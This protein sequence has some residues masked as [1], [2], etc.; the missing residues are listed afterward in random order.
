M[1]QT[2]ESIFLEALKRGPVL[3]LDNMH[4][5]THAATA[6]PIVGFSPLIKL[7]LLAVD[8]GADPDML[9]FNDPARRAGMSEAQAADIT[10]VMYNVGADDPEL[11]RALRSGKPALGFHYCPLNAMYFVDEFGAFGKRLKAGRCKGDNPNVTSP[12]VWFDP[13]PAKFDLDNPRHLRTLQLVKEHFTRQG[14]HTAAERLEKCMAK[15]EVTGQG[16]APID[17]G[18]GVDA[19]LGENGTLTVTSTTGGKGA[20]PLD[21]AYLGPAVAKYEQAFTVRG[22]ADL[23]K[24]ASPISGAVDLAAAKARADAE[25]AREDAAYTP[26]TDRAAKTIRGELREALNRCSAENSSN[27]PDFILAE[28]LVGTLAAFNHA[29]NERDRWHGTNKLSASIHGAA[30]SS[31]GAT[32]GEDPARAPTEEPVDAQHLQDCLK[33]SRHAHIPFD[34]VQAMPRDKLAMFLDALDKSLT[35]EAL[36]AGRMLVLGKDGGKSSKRHYEVTGK[37]WTE[38][39][40]M[41]RERKLDELLPL[42]ERTLPK[43]VAAALDESEQRASRSIATVA[44]FV[45]H[46]A[47]LTTSELVDMSTADLLDTAD[48]VLKQNRRDMTGLLARAEKAEETLSRVEHELQCQT[49]RL[50]E[51]ELAA[52]PP[53]IVCDVR[54]AGSSENPAMVV[55]VSSVAGLTRTPKVISVARPL[56]MFCFRD[57]RRVDIAAIDACPVSSAHPDG[58]WLLTLHGAPSL[59]VGVGVRLYADCTSAT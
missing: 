14:W 49:R 25:L 54:Q 6:D 11:M 47:G 41:L 5:R 38:I 3:L 8:L 58:P 52:A 19:R 2:I 30:V 10:A 53:A 56:T 36:H 9:R 26:P 18:P 1:S 13:M 33:F 17:L 7:A 28:L 22:D 55:T 15:P 44:A 51:A 34:E 32:G 12:I 45:Q 21:P 39:S 50:G 16:S 42:C 29:V 4:D 57:S 59:G 43:M 48:T 46:H 24:L 31:A 27:T 23:E 37:Q 35:A 20:P 40:D